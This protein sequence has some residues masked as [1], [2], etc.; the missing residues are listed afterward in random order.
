MP[1]PLDSRWCP[2]SKPADEVCRHCHRTL[3]RWHHAFG[4]FDG[5]KGVK[6]APVC[7]PSCSAPWWQNPKPEGSPSVW[8]QA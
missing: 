5:E 2:C 8:A 3:C 1:G 6:L 7:M 4:P